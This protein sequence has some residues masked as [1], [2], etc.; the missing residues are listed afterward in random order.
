MREWNQKTPDPLNRTLDIPRGMRI[1]VVYESVVVRSVIAWTLECSGARASLVADA[2]EALRRLGGSEFDL[3]VADALVPPSGGIDLLRRIRSNPATRQLPVIILDSQGTDEIAKTAF[4]EGA[5]ACISTNQSR[6]NL[7]DE[8]ASAIKRVASKKGKLVLVV[9][10]SLTVRSLVKKSLEDAGFR[11]IEAENG[12][13]GLRCLAHN[14]PDLILSDIDM[15]E[16]NGEEFCKA[17]HADPLTGS[18]PFVVMSTNNQRPLM[19]RMLQLGADAYIVK[20]F[21]MDQLVITVE[22]LL[23]DRLLLLQKEKERLEIEQRLMVASITSLCAALE[24]R[25]AYTRG[26]SDAVSAIA[27]RIARELG[28]PQEDIDLI[29]LGGRL[30]DIGKIGVQDSIL[31]KPG[32]LSDEEFAVIKKHPVIGGEIL[33]PVPSLAP[34]LPIVLYHHERIDGKGYP[35]GLSGSSIPLWARITAVGDTYHALTSDRPY[36]KGMPRDKAL[37]ILMQAKGTQL[38]PECVEAFITME[39]WDPPASPKGDDPAASPPR[40]AV[41]YP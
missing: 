40:A 13:A 14:R 34:I 28:L 9:D 39:L 24:A 11:V 26:H 29:S 3:V 33:R 1:L 38:C 32:K 35:E 30:H 37:E 6:E 12:K 15:P 2:D 21:N 23:S 31:L 4:Q 41:V 22:K 16:M 18:I 20:P 8:L 19:R 17:V 36:R 7:L 27:E 5:A 10:D 25:D